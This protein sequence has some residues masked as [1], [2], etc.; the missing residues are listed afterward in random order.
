[1]ADSNFNAIGEEALA[2]IAEE[3]KRTYVAKETGKALS[4]NNFDNN[5]KEKLAG[6]TKNY[7]EL[8]NIPILEG[9][10][11]K[12]ELT[13]ESIGFDILLQTVLDSFV[14]VVRHHNIDVYNS[15]VF[16]EGTMVDTYTVNHMTTVRLTLVVN[17]TPNPAIENDVP[18]V[19]FDDFLP[20]CY[21]DGED[22]RAWDH[23]GRYSDNENT[24]LEFTVDE[25][26]VLSM[27]SR[28]QIP[29]D[30]TYHVQFSYVSA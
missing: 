8:D 12:G 7:E 2:A 28:G 5:A 14:P 26:G 23:L 21:T 24:I 11:L 13:F 1:M 16:G 30:R 9:V 15:G 20:P 18:I 27:T 25:N 29:S 22:N 6:L 3:I 19:V 4:D 10:E 17:E